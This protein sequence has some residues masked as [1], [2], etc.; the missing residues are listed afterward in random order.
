MISWSYQSLR[1]Q[2]N[3][4]RKVYSVMAAISGTT[5]VVCRYVLRITR[6]WLVRLYGSVPVVIT[7]TILNPWHTRATP[8]A[9]SNQ[10]SVFTHKN[11]EL[12]DTGS[13]SGWRMASD[14]DSEFGPP[15]LT[16][17]PIST[18]RTYNTREIKLCSNNIN[19][20]RGKKLELQSFLEISGFDVVAIQE[21]KID[22]SV[23]NTEFFPPELSYSIFRKDRVMGGGGVLLAVKSD[24]NPTPCSPSISQPR[25]AYGR[26]YHRK[27]TC[28]I[29]GAT[30]A[31]PT[32]ITKRCKAST[33]SSN[34]SAA[35][36]SHKFS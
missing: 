10:F 33:N 6:D 4:T 23:S 22:S 32:S 34:K 7:R 29:S 9:L 13:D 16:S 2:S 17:S 8:A 19:S 25:R 27:A 15:L 14:T 11:Q 1:N 30:I 21:T 36:T 18:K 31:H 20:I 24:L 3:P 5:H 28:I 12:S 26:K 35:S